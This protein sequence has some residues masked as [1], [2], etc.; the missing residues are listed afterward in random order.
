MCPGDPASL[1][2]RFLR[3][4]NAPDVFLQLLQVKADLDRQL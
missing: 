2:A 4:L 3:G 1:G